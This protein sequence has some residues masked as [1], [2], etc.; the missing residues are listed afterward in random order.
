MRI[1]KLSLSLTIA[2]ALAGCGGGG[3]GSGAGAEDETRD[4]ESPEAEGML[5]GRF[6]DSAVSGLSFRTNTAWGVTDESGGFSYSAGES[7]TFSI[8]DI[9][10][11]PI[12]AQALV[13]PLDVFSTDDI[14]DARVINLTRLLQTLD[15]DGDPVNGIEISNEATSN[16]FGL[17]VDFASANFDQSVINLVANSGS[18]STS[19]IDGETA[20]DHF[21]ETLF[22]DGIQQRPTVDNTQPPAVD[23]T[24]NAADH[25][26]VGVSA[27][28]SNFAHDI[29]GTLTVLDNR[30]LEIS[31][32]GYDGGGPSVFFYTGVGGNY[33]SSAGG[34]LIGPQ[35]NGRVY[36][37]ETIRVTLPDDLTLD[38]FDGVSVWCDIFS[39]NFGDARF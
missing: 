21:Q 5:N 4:Q 11:P 38:D 23:N 2:L 8:G 18:V 30:T 13:T 24:D 39:A 34:R 35:L 26:L 9:S 12:A 6:V 14:A 29:N 15:V 37:N 17:N 28:F 16:A 20:L 3:G 10:L 33:R 25:P 31:N 19:L 36:D 27:E 32:F 1:V 22:G 7:I